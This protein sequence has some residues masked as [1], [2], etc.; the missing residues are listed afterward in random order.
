MG[1]FVM[2]DKIF[3]E[4]QTIHTIDYAISWLGSNQNL[5]YPFRSDAE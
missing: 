4:V 3:S 2:E 5:K 1:E